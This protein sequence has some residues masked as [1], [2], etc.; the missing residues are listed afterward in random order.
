VL[1]GWSVLTDNAGERRVEEVWVLVDARYALRI[2]LIGEKLQVVVVLLFSQ[3]IQGLEPVHV[4]VEIVASQ[5]QIPTSRARVTFELVVSFTGGQRTDPWGVL[6]SVCMAYDPERPCG[7][8]S[9][10]RLETRLSGP[11]M[12]KLKRLPLVTAG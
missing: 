4:Q 12:E 3:V 7:C 8:P 10:P 9:R 2:S 1:S 5:V 6:V 11:P